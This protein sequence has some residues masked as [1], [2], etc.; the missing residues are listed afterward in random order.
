MRLPKATFCTILILFT[1]PTLT[2]RAQ[3]SSK[4]SLPTNP[5]YANALHE[6]H[7]YLDPEPALY[8]GSQYA[9]YGFLLQEG[10]PYFGEDRMRKGTV[11]YD[12]ILY[13]NLD[14]LYDEVKDQVIIPDN[15]RIFKVILINDL[16]KA[17]TIEHHSFIRLSDSLNPS[18]P[19]NG[20]YE[21]LYKGRISLLKKEIKEITEDLT[22]PQ[23]GIR[24][25][26]SI[27]ISYYIRR[28]EAYYPVNNKNSL[29][30][31]LKDK[32]KEARKFIRKNHLKIKREGKEESLEQ[33]VAWYDSLNN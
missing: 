18:Q 15:D 26:I 5:G 7:T 1:L 23:E 11:W 8:R 9:E 10:H 19:R 33:V 14:L 21:Q 3:L 27:H 2:I 30:Y 13:E 24:R 17:F 6:Y 28:G 32:A 29:L 4:D 31:A 16:V 25:Y 22:N 20:I 12:G